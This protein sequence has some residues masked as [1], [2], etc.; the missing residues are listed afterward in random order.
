MKEDIHPHNQ[1]TK[2]RTE[3]GATDND[4]NSMKRDML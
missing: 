4:I 3:E 2:T 1:A